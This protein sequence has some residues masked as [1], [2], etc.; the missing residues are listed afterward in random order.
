[1][2]T[3]F[4]RDIQLSGEASMVAATP[5]DALIGAAKSLVGTQ[6]LAACDTPPASAVRAYLSANS[7]HLA[8]AR[9]ALAAGCRVPLRYDASFFPE[10]SEALSPLRNL[11]QS[12]A[13]E[14]QQAAADG[15][16]SAA[17]RI[18][19]DLLD[20]ANAIRRGGLVIDLLVSIAV[21]S[22]AINLL[23]GVRGHLDASDRLA[24]IRQLTRTEHDQEPVQEIIARDRHW[25]SAVGYQEEKVELTQQP[26]LDPAEC[27]LTEDQQREL[28]QHMQSFST[29]PDDARRSVYTN[30]DRGTVALLRMLAVDLALRSWR[31]E[32]GAYPDGL[33]PLA[34]MFVEG[35]PD[36]P[37]TQKPFCYRRLADGFVLYSPGPTGIDHGGSF[38]PW[39]MVQAGAADLCLDSGD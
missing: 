25:E 19:V 37:F 7:A 26:L 2:R 1:M 8:T 23:R 36:D 10:H 22:I 20:L 30:R 32:Q 27:G 18:G 13:L 9:G 17:A 11:A 34:P 3:E 35:V 29:M 16:H 24:L 5:Y 12:F 33:G 38:G 39:P 14:L 21:A 31:A 15:D 4:L 6:M 28:W